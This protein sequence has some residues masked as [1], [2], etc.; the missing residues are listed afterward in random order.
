LHHLA[1]IGAIPGLFTY[2]FQHAGA[3]LAGISP[4]LLVLAVFLHSLLLPY[5]GIPGSFGL[6]HSLNGPS[7][8]LFQE[9]LVNIVYALIGQKLSK[10]VLGALVVLSGILLTVAAVRLNTLQV[11]WDWEHFYMAP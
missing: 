2:L 1:V 7:W 5:S 9:Y 8:S 6:T 11:G 3:D 4:W 10:K